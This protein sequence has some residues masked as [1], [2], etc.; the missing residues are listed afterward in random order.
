MK[1]LVKFMAQNRR[2]LLMLL[3]MSL[4]V[5]FFVPIARVDDMA[6]NNAAPLLI[7]L[8]LFVTFC[9]VR[10]R[11]LRITWLHLILILFQLIAAPVVYWLLLPLGDVVA[12]GGM[13]CFLAPIAMAAVAVGALLGAN[14]TTM[15]SYTL[16]CNLVMAFVAPIYLDIFGNG[17]C[18]FAQILGRVVPLLISPLVMAQTLKFVWHKA[19]DWIGNHS[20]MA[21]Y[22]WL[23]SMALTLA[24]TTRYIFEVIDTITILTAVS[25][26]LVALAA[27]VA[28]YSV[29]RVL[30]RR[31]G[32][33]VAGAQSL[34][35][36]NTVLAVWLSQAFLYPVSSIAPTSYIIWQNLVNSFQIYLHDRRER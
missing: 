23:V 26:A 15:V 16:I 12:Q 7:F 11:D 28:Q 24:R 4:G 14:V 21:F 22:M 34:G 25:L 20:Q 30:G 29:G 19:A 5:I 18:T 33:G 31:F 35:Q 32:D 27:C 9:R 3:A 1:N 2:P 10:L 6:N 13:I 36:K 17:E 8:M